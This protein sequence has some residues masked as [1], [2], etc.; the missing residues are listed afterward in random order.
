MTIWGKIIPFIPIGIVE[1]DSISGA[2]TGM[3]FLKTFLSIFLFKNP[4]T[5]E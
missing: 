1:N 4:G 3:Y 5:D 2:S